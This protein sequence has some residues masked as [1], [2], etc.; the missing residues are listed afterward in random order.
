LQL[1]NP[2]ISQATHHK[3]S[4]ANPTDVKEDS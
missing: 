2:L 4:P 1:E 3:A